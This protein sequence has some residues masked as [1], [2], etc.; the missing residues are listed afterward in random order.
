MT[1]DGTNRPHYYLKFQTADEILHCFI[2]LGSMRDA[3][4]HG[5]HEISGKVFPLD[6]K[7]KF[8][9]R[10]MN[11]FKY[12]FVQRQVTGLQRKMKLM[13]NFLV[14]DVKQRIIELGVLTR[15]QCLNDDTAMR[16]HIADCPYGEIHPLRGV[17]RHVNLYYIFD[18]CLTFLPI[19]Y[20]FS[21][22][23]TS[24]KCSKSTWRR[25]EET[26]QIHG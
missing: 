16:I 3:M 24:T 10:K 17:V 25:R 21:A 5:D 11:R 15:S 22:M 8:N 9:E 12:C 26:T 13:C 2:W 19:K 23:W 20:T 18:L 4:R 14:H 6:G 1:T 7:A